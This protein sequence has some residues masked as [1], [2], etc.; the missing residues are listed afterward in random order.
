MRLGLNI[1]PGETEA[2]FVYSVLGATQNQRPPRLRAFEQHLH[3]TKFTGN[4]FLVCLL[5][6]KTL[7]LGMRRFAGSSFLPNALYAARFGARSMELVLSLGSAAAHPG[8]A[9][10][11]GRLQVL[12]GGQEGRGLQGGWQGQEQ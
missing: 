4:L 10:A 2:V 6:G 1:S 7:Q 5:A 9:V 3:K 12:V 11:G 8:S